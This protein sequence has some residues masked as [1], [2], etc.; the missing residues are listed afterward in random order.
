MLS[1]IVPEVVVIL[2]LYDEACKIAVL[3][4]DFTTDFN[5]QLKILIF[6]NNQ[7]RY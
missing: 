2:V 5:L 6:K 3:T 1:S 7:C 4:S